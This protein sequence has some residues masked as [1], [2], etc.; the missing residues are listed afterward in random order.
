M[1]DLGKVGA[2]LR[3]LVPPDKDQDPRC[4]RINVFWALLILIVV[5]TFHLASANGYLGRLGIPAVANADELQK[6]DD[7]NKAILKAIY[8]PQIR[9]KIRERCDTGDAAARERI[10]KELDRLLNEYKLGAGKD[11]Q[12][13]PTCAEV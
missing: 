4:W 8:S 9:A 1:N 5:L 3:G 2:H 6:V 12:P 11:F 13:M 7:G 10:N